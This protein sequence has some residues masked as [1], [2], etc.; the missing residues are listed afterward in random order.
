MAMQF[1]GKYTG[2]LANKL[3]PPDIDL[4]ENLIRT[5]YKIIP[6]DQKIAGGDPESELVARIPAAVSRI[7]MRGLT[8]EV[9]IN[10]VLTYN[11]KISNGI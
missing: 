2:V 4:A 1:A 10:L 8:P 9:A 3:Y 7:N 5:A 6:W 11:N